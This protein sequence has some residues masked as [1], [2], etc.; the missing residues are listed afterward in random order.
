MVGATVRAW[1]S[2]PGSDDH[3][4][5]TTTNDSGYYEIRYRGGHWDPA[6]HRVTRW[7]PDIYITVD[8]HRDTGQY[9]RVHKSRTYS[10]HR[11][12][13]GRK[14]DVN[15]AAAPQRAGFD[16]MVRTVNTH[17]NKPHYPIRLRGI[18][19]KFKDDFPHQV[20]LIAMQETASSMSGC[21]SGRSKNNGPKCLAGELSRLFPGTSTGRFSQRNQ[22]GF[23]AG[24][25]WRVIAKSHWELG[26]WLSRRYL[27]EAYL[28]HR[29]TGHRIRFYSTHHSNTAADKRFRQAKDTAQI[30]RQRAQAGELPPIVVG[31]FNAGRSFDGGTPEASVRRMEQHFWRPVNA[32]A[33]GPGRANGTGI[34]IVYIGKKSSFPNSVGNFVPKKRHHIPLAGIP[35]DVPGY[36]HMNHEL[37]DHHSEAY[38]LR[39]ISDDRGDD[40]MYLDTSFYRARYDD[41]DRAFGN[42]TGD[43]VQHFHNHG[44]NEGRVS[45][46][47]FDVAYY[48]QH[49][50]DLRGYGWPYNKRQAIDHYRTNG[51]F[52]GRRTS[53][54][55]DPQYYLG[56][57]A[58][59][60]D[61]FGPNNYMAAAWHF[62]TH[63][64]D[65]GRQGSAE[66]SARRY[67][68]KYWDVRFRYGRNNY[69]GALQHYY[70]YGRSSGRNGQ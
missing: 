30:I 55:F 50:G 68:D 15:L 42:D 67:L 69:W 44:A 60:R 17:R 10:N 54:V 7:R 26:R 5:T 35:A 51:I 29:P 16:L 70:R 21:L 13:Y 63:G 47:W 52:E 57:Y 24:P 46:P 32:L 62:R 8:R 31:D 56:R 19:H 27:I 3:M 22:V 38:L 43:Y 59:L 36:P 12:R 11:L 49:H 9:V 33:F 4:G 25:D 18:A 45:A 61:A 37:T 1:D 6:P 2:D 34:D 64:I 28:E 66:F 40:Q 58:D 39:V 65:E 48:W 23:V 20:G 53:I 14:I 41:L